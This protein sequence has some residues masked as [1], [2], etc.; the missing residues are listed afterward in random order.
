MVLSGGKIVIIVILVSVLKSFPRSSPP[1]GIISC[2]NIGWIKVIKQLTQR[3]GSSKGLCER[4][5][6]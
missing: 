1:G 6:P 2:T 5:T 3:R 4:F